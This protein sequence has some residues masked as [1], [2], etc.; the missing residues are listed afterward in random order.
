MRA[1]TSDGSVPRDLKLAIIDPGAGRMTKQAPA[2]DTATLPS[3]K[4][5]SSPDQTDAQAGAPAGATTLQGDG[6]DDTVTLSAMTRA[7]KPY[8]YSRA[9]WGANEKMREQ[10]RPQ[11]GTVKTGFVHHTVNA[12]N[13]TAAQVP[14]LLRGIYAYHTQSRGWRDIGYN[15][16]VDRFGRI[17]EGRWGG[18]D[19]AVVGAH[20]LG[21]NEVSFAM[22]AIGNFDIAHPPQAVLDAYARLFAWKL[23]LYNIPADAT[24]LLVKG[25]R[26]HAINGHRDVGQTACPGRY[27]YAKIPWIRT[28]AR[29][30][31]VAAQKG[32][33]G[34]TTPPPTKPA[35]KPPVFTSPT[36]TARPAVSQP[37]SLRFPRGL[38]QVGASYPDIVLRGYAGLV[39]V[40]ATGGQTGYRVAGYSR[41][42]WSSMTLLAA[43]NDVTG[44]GKGDVMG[45]IGGGATKVYRG[46]GAGHVSRVGIAPTR[47][48]RRANK[49]VAAGDYNGD[50]RNDVLMRSWK[51]GG[52]YLVRGL[53]AGKFAKP[54]LLAMGWN[55]YSAIAVPGDV[56]GDRRPDVVGVK[57]GTMYV[58][59]NVGG[60]RLGRAVERQSVGSSYNA[61]AGSGRDM[62]GDGV[63]DLLVRNRT[64]GGLGV[65]TG[66]KGST[67]GDTLG[68]FG[69]A[70]RWTKLTTGNMMGSLQPDVVGVGPAGKSLVVM[71]HNGLRNVARLYTT[72]LRLPDATMV[73]N[74]GD[75]NG[76]GKGD[77]IA[78]EGS[79]DRLVLYPGQGNARY[80]AGQLLSTGWKRFVNIAAV[81]DVT[82]D[83]RPD[84]MG[85]VDGGRMTIFPSAGGAKFQAPILAPTNMR[86]FNQIGSG[87]WRT[88]SMPS[89]SVFG[90]GAFF[91]PSVAARGKIASPSNR[92]IGPGDLDGDGRAD[93]VLRDKSGT[94]WLLPGRATGYGAKRY[95]AS[96]YQS[97]ETF[98]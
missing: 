75:W 62:S 39:K 16:L 53:G 84:L 64:G 29:S 61:V 41:G 70:V 36:Q 22:S 31:Q 34:T 80:G 26:L 83:G 13:Y 81:G 90:I 8:I 19:K 76:D 38:N 65:L 74:A 58:F 56:T 5:D 44:D 52:L 54:R 43:V 50:R 55:K 91:V 10:T 18:V 27:L 96:G 72:N 71:A 46:D 98:G 57:A 95:L 32:G 2:I 37:S 79:K 1:E 48:F 47:I 66:R 24:N 49:I 3:A 60:L 9:Q 78:R 20:T 86:T 68:S 33:G 12:N 30:L 14:A 69:G 11:Y 97:Y 7:P 15:Y 67:F 23:S 93:L 85:R 17:W 25:R 28:K 73:L 40:L 45:R 6:V 89:T 21:Y 51:T 94:L 59:P 92:V 35:P 42:P 4:G 63:G 88:T 77:L 87:Y 82:G